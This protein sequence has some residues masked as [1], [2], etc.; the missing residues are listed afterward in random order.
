[1]SA[2]DH[3]HHDHGHD[4]TH[5]KHGHSHGLVD[6]SIVRSKEGVK[7]VSISFAVL[8][9]AS[10]IQVILFGA[11]HSVALLADVIHNAG[12]SLT[13]IPLGLAFL[14]TEQK[15]RAPGWLLHRLCH[16][17]QCACRII[18]S[19]SKVHSPANPNAHLGNYC[20][21]SCGSNWQRTCRCYT[22]ASGQEAQ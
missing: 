13:A 2:H 3:N 1:M 16:T 6:P 22:V 10:I 4:H 21:W 12:D 19:N 5:E 7:A 20:G 17:N 15:G 14:F 8:M 18:P 9:I 11:S